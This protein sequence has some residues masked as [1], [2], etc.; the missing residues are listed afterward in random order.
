MA[1]CDFVVNYDPEKDTSEDITKRI[2]YSVII[3]RIKHKKPVVLFVGA[4]SGEGKSMSALRLQELLCEIQGIDHKKYMEI[5]NVFTPL[6]YPKKLDKLLY[7]KEYKEANI[8][9]MHEAREVVKAKNWQSFLTQSIADVNAMSRS[10]K[11]LITIIISQFIRDITTDIRYTLNFYCTISRPKGKKARLYLHVMWKDDKDLE[12]PKLRKRKLSGYLKLPDGR[13]KR[14]VPQYFE[15]NL[16]DKETVTKFE[17]LDKKAK[18]GIIRR[19]LDKLIDEMKADIGEESEK[20][21]AMVSHYIRHP[22]QIS[23][24][25]KRFRGSWRMKKEA[26]E[27]HN[28]N[29]EEAKIF[30][31]MMSR[32]LKNKGLIET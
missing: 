19:K 30:E 5:M 1:W 21:N 7:D 20:V 6:E 13:Y 22:E 25:G 8:I 2:L 32:E 17:E 29:R 16:P 18:A 15:M 31:Q 26:R 4:D 10:V 24:I 27:M 28:L 14:F 3:K 23:T 9:T 11:R 12:K